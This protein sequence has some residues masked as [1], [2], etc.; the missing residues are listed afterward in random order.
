MANLIKWRLV[1]PVGLCLTVA[2]LAACSSLGTRARH[3]A[4]AAARD[5]WTWAPIAGAAVIAATNSDERLSHWAM[6]ETP[7]FGSREAASDASD[8]YRRY[9]SNSAWATFLV[10]P[11]Q[12]EGNWFTE[13]G[14]YTSGNLMGLAF[15]RS[16]TG[17]LKYATQRERPNGSPVHDSFPSSH[18][19]DAFAHASLARYHTD[20][21]HTF[22]PLREGM[23]WASDGFAFATAWGRVEGGFHYPT[24][25]L[26]GAAVANFT[27]RFFMKLSASTAKSRW[28]VRTRV[29]E[30]GEM[31]IEIGKPL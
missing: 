12:N 8:R 27:T 28:R 13:K 20:D 25:V 1:C 14:T 3:A 30:K 26:I 17:V 18:S 15:A 2:M 21:Q 16:A 31:V 5:P 9:A 19:S 7:V 10:S 4:T 11:A 23:Q 29:D 22:H 6:K 24:D